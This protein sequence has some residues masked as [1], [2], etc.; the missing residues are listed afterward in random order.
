MV[1]SHYGYQLPW[2]PQLHMESQYDGNGLVT[3]TS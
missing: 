3:N 1:T 2:L